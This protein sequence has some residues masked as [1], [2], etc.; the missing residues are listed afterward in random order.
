MGISAG[1][2]GGISGGGGGV[3]GAGGGVSGAGGGISGAGG[4]AFG[5]GGG[6]VACTGGGGVG[7]G[8]GFGAG[9]ASLISSK[10]HN[11]PVTSKAVLYLYAFSSERFDLRRRGVPAKIDSTAFG[12]TLKS[13]AIFCFTSG[14]TL[15][16]LISPLKMILNFCSF[17]SSFTA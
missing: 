3:L 10:L 9:F 2:A 13:A 1:L 16:Y 6:G 11:A 17:I 5:G 15:S 7:A 8:G 12:S 4:G 14:R